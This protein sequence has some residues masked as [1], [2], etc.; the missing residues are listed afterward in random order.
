MQCQDVDKSAWKRVGTQAV[1]EQRE[2]THT[3]TNTHGLLCFRRS[4]RDGSVFL[5]SCSCY[6]SRLTLSQHIFPLSR[7]YEGV[8]NYMLWPVSLTFT[9]AVATEHLQVGKV[10]DV[11]GGGCHGEQRGQVGVRCVG[12]KTESSVQETNPGLDS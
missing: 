4:D 1:L 2:N 9:C 11:W 6:S 12:R 7:F 3:H 8:F 5:M 10:L